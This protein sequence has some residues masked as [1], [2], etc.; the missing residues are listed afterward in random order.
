MLRTLLIPAVG[1]LL[2]AGAATQAAAQES[3]PMGLSIR[4]GLF[5]PSDSAARDEGKT[6]FAF[7]GEFRLSDLQLGAADPAYTA[8]LSVSADFF[9]KGD[10]RNVPVLLNYVGRTN[11]LYYSAGAGLGFARLPSGTGTEDKTRFAYQLSIGYDF[12]QGRNPFFA[13]AKYFGSSESA[14]S[15]FGV[16]IGM[17]L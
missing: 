8:H 14:L 11:E 2:I 13:E 12:Q 16:Y 1:A 17:R 4:A 3:K 7:G 10:Y 6:W 9:G 15:G 5:F